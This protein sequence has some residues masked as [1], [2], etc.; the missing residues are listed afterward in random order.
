MLNLYLL[1][2][3]TWN[4]YKAIHW[5][6]IWPCCLY[7]GQHIKCL[8]SAG[9]LKG[10]C[11]PDRH[12]E[13]W[14]AAGPPWG[15]ECAGWK[16]SSHSPSRREASSVATPAHTHRK[17]TPLWFNALLVGI[18]NCSVHMEKYVLC[19]FPSLCGKQ[20]TPVPTSIKVEE[21]I[22]GGMPTVG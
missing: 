12:P 5:V 14:W 17:H 20:Q 6:L 15:A 16:S 3:C 4:I 18:N 7:S 11:L 2:T 21:D 13:Q 8:H 22:G 9:S 19:V 1:T 10:C